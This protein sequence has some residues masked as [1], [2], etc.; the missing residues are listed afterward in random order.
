MGFKECSNALAANQSHSVASSRPPPDP[1]SRTRVHLHRSTSRLVQC[2][3][4]LAGLTHPTSALSFAPTTAP[5][6]HSITWCL[7]YLWSS[8]TSLCSRW[9][10]STLASLTYVCFIYWQFL[11][12]WAGFVGICVAMSRLQQLARTAITLPTFHFGP[13]LIG[14]AYYILWWLSHYQTLL[15]DIPNSLL[16]WFLA[17]QTVPV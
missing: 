6:H 15:N 9:I 8:C 4:L 13:L 11:F 2:F 16:W 17:L 12:I 1:D 5:Y 10:H 7:Q 3:G 14:S